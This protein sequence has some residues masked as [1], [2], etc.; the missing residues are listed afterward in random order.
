MHAVRWCVIKQESP[1]KA[2]TFY[3]RSRETVASWRGWSWGCVTCYCS[4]LFASRIIF[5][6]EEPRKQAN[7][8]QKSLFLCDFT[9]KHTPRTLFAG[10]R[11]PS[12]WSLREQKAIYIQF[13]MVLSWR[14]RLRLSN[15][16]KFFLLLSPCSLRARCCCGQPR[17]PTANNCGIILAYFLSSPIENRRLQELYKQRSRTR[18]STRN[19]KKTSFVSFFLLLASAVPA[20]TAAREE[21]K[22]NEAKWL[23]LSSFNLRMAAWWTWTFFYIMADRGSLRCECGRAGLAACIW[24]CASDMGK[25]CSIARMLIKILRV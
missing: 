10:F 19:E 2:K 13:R 20:I 24:S 25:R 16:K 12:T 5:R 18:S 15:A 11:V 17:F 14:P 1:W 6:K 8:S 9:P 4:L 7:F 23:A 21:K 22:A 3:S